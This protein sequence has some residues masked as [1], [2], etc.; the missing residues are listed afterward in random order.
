MLE[1][2]GLLHRS[3]TTSLPHLKKLVLRNCP[4]LSSS[5]CC[6]QSSNR[7]GRNGNLDDGDLN[8]T[9]SR[10][11]RKRDRTLEIFGSIV[12]STDLRLLAV[13]LDEE[14]RRAAAQRRSR[15]VDLRNNV[16][17]TSVEIESRQ[18]LDKFD[19]LCSQMEFQ[20]WVLP[21][22]KNLDG[23]K[24]FEILVTARSSSRYLTLIS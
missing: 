18:R 19:L 15:N 23:E 5:T 22:I 6:P 21:S 9:A 14:E 16:L 10:R 4:Q 20:F 1:N 13:Q 8:S 17:V 7:R 11:R 3:I 2:A 12:P 24:D